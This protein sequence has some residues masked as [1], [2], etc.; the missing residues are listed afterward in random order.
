[1]PKSAKQNRSLLVCLVWPLNGRDQKGVAEH[2]END[3]VIGN[4]KRKFTRADNITF[5]VY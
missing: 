4:A 5:D 1:M 2:L 3:A